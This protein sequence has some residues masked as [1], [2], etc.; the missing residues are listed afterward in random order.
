MSVSSR[1]R[2]SK[3]RRQKR[4]GRADTAFVEIN[5]FRHN[6]GPYDDPE[7]RAKYKR[8]ISGDSADP[9]PESPPKPAPEA[10]PGPPT[11][12]RVLAAFLTEEKPNRIGRDG[13]PTRAYGHFITVAKILRHEFGN[14]PAHLFG[15]KRLKIVRDVMLSRGWTRDYINRMVRRVVI[16]FRWAVSEELIEPTLHR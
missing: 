16:I 7:S 15:P 13:K 2:V 6:L 11:V 12:N 3:Y 9:P 14:L 4:K 10:K 1:K 5:G 8:L